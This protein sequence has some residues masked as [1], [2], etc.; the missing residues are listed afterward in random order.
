MRESEKRF[1][2]IRSV[3]EANLCGARF[4]SS[5]TSDETFLQS[6]HQGVYLLPGF[7]SKREQEM[8]I[9]RALTNWNEPPNRRN[10]EAD[11]RAGGESQPPP[12][13]LFEK[14]VYGDQK[15]EGVLTLTDLTWSTLG[16]HY[17]WTNR[18]YPLPS[19]LPFE[20][21]I[22]SSIWHSPLPFDIQELVT[23]VVD[24]VR[25]KFSS[26]KSKN[27]EKLDVSPLEVDSFPFIPQTV[28]VNYYSATT[29]SGSKFPM[30]AHR[31]DLETAIK[32][33]VVSLSL[34]CACV[35]LLEKE[36]NPTSEPT[37]LLLRS[38][39]ALILSGKSRLSL[40]GVP[41]V[42]EKCV[43]GKCDR[44]NEYCTH[45]G[46]LELFDDYETSE[47]NKVALKRYIQNHR[48]NLNA[49]QVD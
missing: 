18:S 34:G 29:A 37:A 7:L 15:R 23:R 12:S 21:D 45:C 36:S 40:H 48:I 39:D 25:F 49:R 42:F 24:T 17:D 27:T 10:F 47:I 13:L 22:S 38:G 35:F 30:G 2:K 11:G 19:L 32:S 5:V 44:E 9:E 31:D 16:R 41:V 20:K 28:I 46:C 14:Y 6:H 1:R 3:K 43:E 26:S 8:Y 4:L 33:P